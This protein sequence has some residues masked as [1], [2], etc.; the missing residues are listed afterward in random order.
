MSDKCPDKVKAAWA[1]RVYGNQIFIINEFVIL[2]FQI[3]NILETR[4]C[5]YNINKYF[6]DVDDDGVV[7]EEDIMRVIDQL[8]SGTDA[9]RVL[10]IEEKSRIAKVV[11]DLLYFYIN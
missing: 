3:N 9:S 10:D 2:Y 11:S 4:G 5:D 1:F 7:G 6:L 8:T